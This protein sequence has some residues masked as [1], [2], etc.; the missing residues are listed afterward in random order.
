M[1]EEIDYGTKPDLPSRRALRAR[2]LYLFQQYRQRADLDRTY[3]DWG[4]LIDEHAKFCETVIKYFAACTCYWA[5]L[6]MHPVTDVNTVTFARLR[7]AGFEVELR[8]GGTEPA[9]WV[10]K[11]PHTCGRSRK[12]FSAE[13][14]RREALRDQWVAEHPFQPISEWSGGEIGQT[15]AAWAA[16]LD[17]RYLCDVQMV[18]YRQYLCVFDS[19]GTCFF[20][21]EADVMHGAVFGADISDL[22]AWEQKCRQIVSKLEG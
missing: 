22:G 2:D 16:I 12:A 19:D 18:F 10:A 3:A 8:D 21:E 11:W 6:P 14:E 7:K 9:V 20:S 4:R 13:I 17:D 1:N 15:E 5:E